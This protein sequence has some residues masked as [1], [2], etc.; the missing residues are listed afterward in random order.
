VA[1]RGLH[2]P[3][4]VTAAPGPVVLV[5]AVASGGAI[6][7]LVLRVPAAGLV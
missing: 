3:R 7:A 4:G 5:S 2:H 6:E 1:A